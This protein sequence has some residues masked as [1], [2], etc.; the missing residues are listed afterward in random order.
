MDKRN[1]GVFSR[2]NI[3]FYADAAFDFSENTLLN[4]TGRYENYSDF[5]NALVGKVSFRQKLNGD[6]FVMRASA[7]TGFKAPS[8]H[9]L[10]LSINKA[11]FSGGTIVTD[12]LFS[13]TSKEARTLGVPQLKAEKSVNLTLGLGMQPTKNT[14]ITLDGYYIGIK[15]RI[16][17]SSRLGGLNMPGVSSV[18]FF[19]NGI[20]TQ[21]MGLDLVASFRNMFK[22]GEGN[23]GMNLAANVNTTKVSGDFKTPAPILAANPK[24]VMFNRTEAAL[25]T[26]SRPSYKAVFGFDYNTGSWNIALNNTAFGPAKFVNGD[27]G[28]DGVAFNTPGADAMP[29]LQYKTRI[30][31]DLN[32]AYKINDKNTINFGIL[33]L[34]NV[35]PKW[36]IENVP[37]ADQEKIYNYITFNGR[38]PQS[39]YDSQHFSIFGT[40]FTLGYNVKF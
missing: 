18:S 28:Q 23:V 37:A 17:L 35:I 33:N 13:N 39:A 12:G 11:S 25:N 14:S 15:D 24:A 6:K 8:L 21:T 5:G 19:I 16:V 31:S 26:T 32:I 2:Y 9:Q 29:Y 4:L 10:N 3:G 20:D 34:F 40:Q 22:I 30:V 27:I 38:Y 36:T 7:S 1:A